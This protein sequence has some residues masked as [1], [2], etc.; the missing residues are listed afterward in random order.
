MGY[1]P[2]MS[3]ESKGERTP[4]VAA[5]AGLLKRSCA[6]CFVDGKAA[7]AMI[8]AVNS[9]KENGGPRFF[10][11][12][13]WQAQSGWLATSPSSHQRMHLA[14]VDDTDDKLGPCSSLAATVNLKV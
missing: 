1:L 5:L 12:I 10:G 9:K 4:L 11:Y 6:C 7:S 14:V 2:V 8:L 3:G 13:K